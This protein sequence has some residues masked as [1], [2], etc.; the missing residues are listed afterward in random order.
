[1][2]ANILHEFGEPSQ[3]KLEEIQ[4]PTPKENQVLICVKAIG[5]NPLDSKVRKGANRI[6]KNMT[7]P[8]I[9]GWDVSGVISACG[10]GVSQW[11]TGDE[12]FGCIG[13]PGPG[14]AYAEYVA[15]NADELVRKPK[16]VSFEEAAALPIIGLTAY[17]AIHEHLKIQSGQKVLIQAAAG[18][19]GHL[20]VQ[21]AKQAGAYVYAT[22]SKRNHAFLESLGANR[23]IDYKNEKFEE[24]AQELDAVQ[25]AI[26]G[27][28]LYRS[29]G[30]TR[31][32]GKVICLPSST[33]NDPKAIEIAKEQNVNL[34]WP[35]MY[36]N[37]EHLEIL[38]SQMAAGKL[39]INI[40]QVFAFDKMAQAHEAVETQATRGKIVV[41]LQV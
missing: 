6:A 40:D 38:S 34:Q 17:Q 16:E 35:I 27:D 20:S 36:I 22:A 8:A 41:S 10:K 19:V 18:G 37:P 23:A 39:K 1:M 28:I 32:N 21:L 9:I 5:I 26:G 3:F 30:C 12:V 24:I 31:K 25:G 13:F 29:I 33:K 15:V 7:L 11:Q 4:K 2:K 14:G